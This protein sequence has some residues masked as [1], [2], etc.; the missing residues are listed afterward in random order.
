MSLNSLL[1]KRIK[2]YHEQG[3]TDKVHRLEEAIRHLE[4]RPCTPEYSI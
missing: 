4:T 1:L 2:E 3:D